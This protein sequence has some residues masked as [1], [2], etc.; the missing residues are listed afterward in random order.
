M[1]KSRVAKRYARALFEFALDNNQL[2]SAAADLDLLDA[3]LRD[4]PEFRRLIDSP[5][6]SNQAKQAAFSA[7]FKDRLQAD[8]FKFV[9]FLIAKNREA[10]LPDIV[11]EFRDLLDEHRGILR[12]EVSSVMP[13]SELQLH[14]LKERLNR[15][16]GKNVLITQH[17]DPNLLGGLVV[18]IR[19]TVY[20]ASL[21]NK[22]EKL[23]QSLVQS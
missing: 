3:A 21:R 8:T 17:T 15:L 20:D 2:E 16:T 22:L 13:L 14:N 11:A 10:V 9:S 1:I 4:S 12:G 18:R 7:L 6:I 5:V 19:D 23:R